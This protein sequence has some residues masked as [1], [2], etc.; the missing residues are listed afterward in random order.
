MHEERS[1]W[2]T[3]LLA[4]PFG[5][6]GFHKF[7]LRQNLMGCIYLFSLG[8]F[9]LGWLYDLFTIP[10][11]VRTFNRELQHTDG[12]AEQLEEEIEDLEEEIMELEEEILELKSKQVPQQK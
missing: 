8:L 6:F 4:I 9:G 1:V 5:I 11:Q 7:Y 3:Y 10:S 12:Y 2:V